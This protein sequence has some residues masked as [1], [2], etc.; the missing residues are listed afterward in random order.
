MEINKPDQ[1]VLKGMGRLE[2][3]QHINRKYF[4][5]IRNIH[6]FDLTHHHPNTT[7]TTCQRF[8]SAPK[9][10]PTGY[11]RPK[12]HSNASS[13]QLAH[14]TNS[15]FRS[16]DRVMPP[17]APPPKP[18][19]QKEEGV[20]LG[21]F[22]HSQQYRTTNME[23]MQNQTLKERAVTFK[24]R[25]Q[26]R[27]DP[28]TGNTRS[29]GFGFEDYQANRNNQIHSHNFSQVPTNRFERVDII[30]GRKMTFQ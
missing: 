19:K 23:R 15:Y 30:S 21:E 27:F 4:P 26:V 17:Q 6:Q 1:G 28:I 29:F 12:P 8:F 3:E 22:P 20:H 18:I 14:D 5:K 11:S 7:A 16:R 25:N 2:V 9:P 13:I 24:N 10:P